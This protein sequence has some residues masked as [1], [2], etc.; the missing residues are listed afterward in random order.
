MNI[1][2]WIAF[3]IG[4]PSSLRVIAFSYAGGSAMLYK[5]LFNPK[6]LNNI[7]VFGIEIPGRGKRFH[8]KRIVNI[9]DLIEKLKLVVDPLYT[10]KNT[11]I[12]GYS[13]G[14][15]LAYE[16]A[17]YLQEQGK[18]LHALCIIAR[19]PP[20]LSNSKEKRGNYSNTELKKAMIKLNGT[21]QDILNSEDVL[22]FYLEILKDDFKLVDSYC[23]KK[24]KILSSPLYIYGGLYDNEV[25][26]LEL[27]QW[28]KYTKSNF[29]LRLF[30]G[31]HFFV[32]N[33]SEIFVNQ[34]LNDLKEEY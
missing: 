27:N 5:N 4:T 3:H 34:L 30:N 28:N 33:C 12:L 6:D 13:L 8:E 25:S 32:N 15:L 24:I 7:E 20:H 14:A 21:P 29:K 11:I 2:D 31:N 16:I 23:F 18:L 26:F 19:T 1:N 10:P 9:Y 22:K 17:L